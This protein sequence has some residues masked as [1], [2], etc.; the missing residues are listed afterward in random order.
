MSANM[1]TLLA[2]KSMFQGLGDRF[3]FENTQLDSSDLFVAIGVVV[4]GGAVV[5]LMAT[6]MRRSER[7]KTVDNPKR[8]FQEL[9]QAHRLERH[10][11]AQL[12]S[13][14]DG[15]GLENPSLL[16]IDPGL[17]DA[18]ILDLR[19]SEESPE[20]GRYRELIF[21]EESP[22]PETIEAAPAGI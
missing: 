6:Y 3:R 16:F 17:L 15:L 5:W 13:I 20:L 4:V 7:P 8:L 22:P 21:G 2:E 14:A 12:R 1:W 9:C 18:A 10:E 19:W 11:G